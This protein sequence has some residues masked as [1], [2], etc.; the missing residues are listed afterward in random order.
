MDLLITHLEEHLSCEVKTDLEKMIE[1]IPKIKKTF[2]TIY[3]FVQIL[4]KTL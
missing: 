3:N 2:D 4:E 1:N